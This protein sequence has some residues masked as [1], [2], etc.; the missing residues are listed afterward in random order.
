LSTGEILSEKHQEGK[1]KETSELCEAI[2]T[3]CHPSAFVEVLA[4]RCLAMGA[5]EHRDT[6]E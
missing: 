6:H 1:R 5:G 3:C 2:K 4:Y